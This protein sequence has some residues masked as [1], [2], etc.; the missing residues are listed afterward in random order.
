[1]IPILQRIGSDLNPTPEVRIQIRS[2]VH[3]E[4]ASDFLIKHTAKGSSLGTNILDSLVQSGSASR[5]FAELV[6]MFQKPGF[7]LRKSV[8]DSGTTAILSSTSAMCRH[9][10]KR[11]EWQLAASRVAAQPQPTAKD[12]ECPFHRSFSR[13]R[14]AGG[15]YGLQI[16]GLFG[17]SMFSKASNSSKLA[18][19]ALCQSLPNDALIDCQ[20]RTDHLLSLVH[21]ISRS[22]FLRSLAN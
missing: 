7:G 19:Y 9:K 21:A 11:A 3:R 12:G 17:E 2:F 18:L 13:R 10:E 8:L 5:A 15:L 14:T 20:Q 1:M 16:E 6:Q 4:C 22:E